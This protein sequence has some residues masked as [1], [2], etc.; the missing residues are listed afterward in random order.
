LAA[1]EDLR[2]NG[3]GAHVVRRF[4]DVSRAA[5][6]ADRR[7]EIIGGGLVRLTNLA[8]TLGTALLL[9]LGA[10]L[11][12]SGAI[13]LGTLLVVFRYSQL[14][15]QPLERIID[16]LK[17]LQRA[18]AGVARAA[19]L[20]AVQSGLRPPNPATAHGLPTRGPLSVELRDVSFG[21][22]EEAVL[23]RVV[24]YLPAAR[25]LGLVGR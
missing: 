5:F 19:E 20:F 1:A 4:H 15:R 10:V 9:G 2:A 23:D 25:T 3:A 11:Q 12:Q 18:Q 13:T 8:F 21:Y 16:Q 24:L 17:E 22:G 14:I 7:A 6:K